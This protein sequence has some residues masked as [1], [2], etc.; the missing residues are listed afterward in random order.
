M[1]LSHICE[2]LLHSTDVSCLFRWSIVLLSSLALIFLASLL[3]TAVELL[4]SKIV[5]EVLNIMNILSNFTTFKVLLF[6][7]AGLHALQL[8]L[9]LLAMMWLFYLNSLLTCVK[10][11][12][13]A[14]PVLSM[15]IETALRTS[16]PCSV[17]M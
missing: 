1:L 5:D 15:W 13:H 10:S 11:I 12:L 16:F 3:E 2:L 8:R 17:C 6:R 9:D 4:G 7:K 14:I